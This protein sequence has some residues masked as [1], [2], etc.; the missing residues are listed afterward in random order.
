VPPEGGIDARRC[1]PLC[2][3]A[4]RE[5]RDDRGCRM[6]SSRMAPSVTR[7]WPTS[8]AAALPCPAR[9][10]GEPGASYC[11]STNPP[12]VEVICTR[13]WTLKPRDAR[14]GSSTRLAS[15]SRQPLSA[16]SAGRIARRSRTSLVS[17]RVG[18][19]RLFCPLRRQDERGVECALQRLDESRVE[20]Q[21]EPGCSNVPF[22]IMR[23]CPGPLLG[24]IRNT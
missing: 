5:P 12:A 19:R 14:S 2:K 4:S 3:A 20:E 22:G 21:R 16:S 11:V 9:C 1:C 8:G 10:P 15:P 24:S 17:V 7:C 13:P 6:N 18:M 23:V